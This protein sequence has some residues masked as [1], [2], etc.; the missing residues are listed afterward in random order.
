MNHVR[1]I[2]GCNDARVAKY[3]G[4]NVCVAILD[5]GVFGDNIELRDRIICFKDFIYGK[6]RYYDENGHG[7]HVAGIIGG[8]GRFSNG[9][10]M[11]MA[12]EC[13]IVALKVLDKNGNGNVAEVL[14]AIDWVIRNRDRYR[15]RVMNISVGMFMKVDSQE[16]TE[17]LRGVEKAWDAGIVVVVAAGNNGPKPM[18]ITVPGI[19]P[20]VITVGSIQ[21]QV[22]RNHYSGRG[23][24]PLCIVKPEIVAPGTNITSCQNS[25]Y[26]YSIKSGTSMSTPVVSG[27]ICLLLEKYPR[28]TPLEVK[29][30]LHDSAVDM[31]LPKNEQGWGCINVPNLLGV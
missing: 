20:K 10:Y 14:H 3:R 26:G 11:G 27:A 31:G 30:R 25:G 15:I 28:M 13:R 21:D 23:P 6:R 16:K 18:T 12:P 22:T 4:K 8:N 17:L 5:T 1:Q 19:S 2:V 7:T 9:K 29:I 24:T